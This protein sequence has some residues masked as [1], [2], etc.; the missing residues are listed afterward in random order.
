[1]KLKGSNK[2]RGRPGASALEW[3]RDLAGGCARATAIGSNRLLVEN[4]T[5][6]LALSD[7]CVR[8]Q[9]GAGAITVTGRELKLCDARRGALIVRGIIERV[10]LP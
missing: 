9:T 5:G 8:L 3:P 2:R 1:M 10:E 6:I 4:H 7:T